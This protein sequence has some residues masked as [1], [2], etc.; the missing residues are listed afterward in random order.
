[1]RNPICASPA[2]WCSLFVSVR[3]DDITTSPCISLVWVAF[4]FYCDKC[5][6]QPSPMCT[7]KKHVIQQTSPIWT[8]FTGAVWKRVKICRMSTLILGWHRFDAFSTSADWSNDWPQAKMTSPLDG[9]EG[10]RTGKRPPESES[11]WSKRNVWPQ[12]KPNL[13]TNVFRSGQ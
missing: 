8:A 1:M 2:E 7:L 12:L 10:D 5:D 13:R 3:C 11:Q 4:D 9:I 6:F